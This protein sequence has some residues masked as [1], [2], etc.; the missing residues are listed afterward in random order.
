MVLPLF[1][2]IDSLRAVPWIAEFAPAPKKGTFNLEV[3]HILTVA[4]IIEATFANPDRRRYPFGRMYS[5]RYPLYPVNTFPDDLIQR[6]AH[7][8]PR[9]LRRFNQEEI[10]LY[11]TI[12]IVNGNV[13]KIQWLEDLKNLKWY[14]PFMYDR[15]DAYM[16]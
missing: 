11:D 2:T 16:F 14:G 1:I 9:A 6:I 13:D 4:S 15:E 10:E 8:M 5:D 12:R 7:K 3:N